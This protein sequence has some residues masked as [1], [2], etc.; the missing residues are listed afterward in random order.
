MR[1]Q[2]SVVK[3]SR[4]RRDVIKNRSQADFSSYHADW[5]HVFVQY[6]LVFKVVLP[7]TC[8]W[9]RSVPLLEMPDRRQKRYFCVIY[10]LRRLQNTFNSAFTYRLI[11][12][13]SSSL[14]RTKETVSVSNN[15]KRL[16][17]VHNVSYLTAPFI[18]CNSAGPPAACQISS[19]NKISSLRFRC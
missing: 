12:W 17:I 15:Y 5:Q 13:G 16:K 19:L 6:G 18:H 14:Y 1:R 10:E 9:I 4:G 7:Y 3:E 2:I 8:R 11:Y